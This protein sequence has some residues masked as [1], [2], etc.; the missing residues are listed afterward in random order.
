MH[1]IYGKY[2]QQQTGAKYFDNYESKVFVNF[3]HYLLD[4]LEKSIN[5]KKVSTFFPK[6]PMEFFYGSNQ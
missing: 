6:L 4:V 2:L 5:H 3:N 1:N